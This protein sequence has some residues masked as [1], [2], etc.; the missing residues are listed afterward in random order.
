MKRV[1]LIAALIALVC[2]GPALAKKNGGGAAVT[3]TVDA[4]LNQHPISPLIYGVT[5]YNTTTLL[6]LNAPLNRL[7]GD[8]YPTY[9]WQLNA[10]NP[11]NDHFFESVPQDGNPAPAG[12]V[13]DFIAVTQAGHAAPMVTVPLLGMV[14]N[15]GPGRTPLASFSIAKYG[16][17]CASD[18]SFPDAGD[19]I[20]TDC[21][22]WLTGNDP[23]DAYVPDSLA[24]EQ[25][26]VQHLVSQWGGAA[27]GGVRYYLMDNEPSNWAQTHRDVHPVGQHANEERDSVIAYSAM[28]KSVDP[29]ALVIAAEEWSW[30]AALYS[31][32]DQQ[33]IDQGTN[34][35]LP[36]RTNIQNG[37]NYLPW[38]LS[39]WHDAGHPIDVVSTHYYPQGGEPGNDVSPAMQ[40]LRNRSTRQLWDP[41]Y[42]T[43]DWM[44]LRIGAIPQLRAW[45][46]A[47]YYAGVPIGI[48]E[49][50][51]GA[52]ANINGATAEADILGIFGREGLAMAGRWLAPDPSTPTYKAMQLYRN[53]DGNDSTFGDVSV[54][55]S[56]PNPDN[57]SAFAALRSSDGALTVMVVNKVLSGAAN[58]TLALSQFTMGGTVQAYQ[59]TAANQIA[60]L[61]PPTV[62][63]VKKIKLTLPAQS[64]TLFVIPGSAQ[65]CNAADPA[66]KKKKGC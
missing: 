54:L 49:Y 38:L 33:L 25:G 48:T 7:G 45:T 28:V 15:L 20:A 22:T 5:T 8:D 21:K 3:V 40:L 61:P 41:N 31:G 36:D 29:N 58:L 65:N 50:S 37:M 17:Q 13:D 4:A 16:A 63:K 39:Q 47:Y 64:I 42:T 27:N 56:A 44:Q 23:S 26:F 19:G 43:E 57:L 11:G 6:G 51:W 46:D 66:K 2:A 30:W 9:N 52:D 53:Y 1:W 34:Q 10:G 12:A 35:P 60:T 18:P 62:K 14:A 24:N 32:F 59:L 55:A